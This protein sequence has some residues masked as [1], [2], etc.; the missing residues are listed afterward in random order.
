[1]FRRNKA[2]QRQALD[3]FSADPDL[4]LCQSQVGERAQKGWAAGIPKAAG[5]SE[6]E[7]LFSHIFTFFNLIFVVL[8]ALLVLGVGTLLK[9]Q[10]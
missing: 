7:I 2:P 10:V 6:Q 5:K 1:M 4:G 3:V 8:A 9:K